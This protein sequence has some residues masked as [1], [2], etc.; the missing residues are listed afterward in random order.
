MEKKWRALEILKIEY[1][2]LSV[3]YDAN[4]QE[5]LKNAMSSVESIQLDV[6][7]SATAAAKNFA[8]TMVDIT[9]EYELGVALVNKAIE[10]EEQNVA[11]GY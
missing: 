4:Q 1:K 6:L 3:Q 5:M 7:G 11:V 10:I 2:M 8:I 9:D